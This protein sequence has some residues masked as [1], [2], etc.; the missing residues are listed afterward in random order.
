LGATHEESWRAVKK[1]DFIAG[2]FVWCGFDFLGEPVP[3]QWPARSSFYGIIDLAG[4]PKDVYYM[5]QSEWTNKPVLH[6]FPHWNGQQGKSIDIWAYYNSA[7]EVELFLNGKSL[8]T[9]RKQG[10]SLHVVWRVR[11]EP[12]TLKAI[13]RKNGKI[14]LTKEKKTAGKPAKIQ[15]IADRKILQANGEDLS[16]ITVRILDANN[17]LVPYADNLVRFS[18]K[19]EG[20]IA[21]VD[22]GNPVS[23]ESFK[24]S[25]RKAFSG[26]CLAIIKSTQKNGSVNLSANAAGLSSAEINIKVTGARNSK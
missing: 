22:N 5:Y 4:F 20:T 1:F 19:G 3:Y 8:G 26:M 25:E 16:F 15:L 24:A 14:I 21:G 10:D 2:T 13:S 23:M 6:I 9:R 11:F 7:D 12:G 18:I 17:N